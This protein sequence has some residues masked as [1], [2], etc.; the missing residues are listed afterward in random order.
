MSCGFQWPGRQPMCWSSYISLLVQVSGVVRASKFSS[1]F[2]SIRKL[3]CDELSNLLRRL[4][5]GSMAGH[6]L[7]RE[8]Q[9]LPFTVISN[10][11]Q[12]HVISQ[13]VYRAFVHPLSNYPSPF[14]YAVSYVPYYLDM[15][16]GRMHTVAK[17]FHDTY[18]DV[19]RISPTHTC[20]IQSST[21]QIPWQTL[22]S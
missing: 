6:H 14:L 12:G 16:L 2:A 9:Y 5:L 18:G 8:Y 15:W 11:H 20:P 1:S 13:V 3:R 22:F 21:N 4:W 10:P 19:V 17:D 7:L